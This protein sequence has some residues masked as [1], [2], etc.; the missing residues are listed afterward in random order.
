MPLIPPIL[1][2]RDFEAIYAEL[3]DRIPV[4]NPAWT[5][6]HE[7]DPGIT[8]L[9]LFA[10]LGEGLQFRFNQIPEATRLAFLKLL[11]L[12]LAPAR[13]AHAL[14]RCVSRAPAGVAVYAGDQ[15]KAGK[16]V[17]TVE[18]DAVLWPLDCVAVARAPLL[19]DPAGEL[20][21]FLA[22]LDAEL[23]A[24][25][26][27]GID[28]LQQADPAISAVAPY[29]PR[30]LEADATSPPLD[31]ADTVDGCVWIAVLK[32]PG[33]DLENVP[34]RAITLSLGYEPAVHYPDIDGAPTCGP[35]APP[36]LEWRASLA[37]PGRDG[38][39]A[40][41]ALRVAG[42]SSA[43]FT[44]AGVVSLEL[45][46]DLAPLGVPAAPAGVAGGGDHPPPLDDERAE[47]VW[48]WLRVWRGDGSRVGLTRAIMVNALAC[49]QAVEAAPELLGG[50]T[51]QPGQM[52]QLA[53]A[54][55]LADARHP[56][57]VQVEEGGVWCDWRWVDSFDASGREDRHFTLDAEAAQIRF[58]ER[59]PQLGERV[60][61]LGY[62]WGGGARGNLPAQALDAFVARGGAPTPPAPL[63]RAPAGIKLAN[64]LPARGG[65]DRESVEAALQRIP[66]TLRHNRRAVARDDFAELARQTPGADIGRAECLPLFHAPS[67]D[68]RAGNVGVVVWPARDPVHPDAPTPDALQL[69]NVC[70]WLDHARLVTTELHVI[71]PTYRRLALSIALKIKPGYGLNAVRD[72]VELLL[73]QYLAP[74]PPYGPD[75][76]GWP[77]GRAVRA[78]ELEGVAMQ[79]EGVEYV[80]ALRLA[81]D[82]AE[83]GEA[84]NWVERALVPLEDWEVPT[85]ADVVVVAGDAAPEP[86]RDLAPPP[87]TPPLPLPVLRDVCD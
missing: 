54:P 41:R 62:R 73:R 57:R 87:V 47:R 15:V 60:R 42:D 36:Q 25:V 68:Y 22:G 1:D 26:Q 44:R 63:L 17:F 35:G 86:G 59:F 34:G 78:R 75:G 61:V 58:G 9:Q 65:V 76:A 64:P 21:A 33:L 13:P 7:S 80:E 8:L 82:T 79:A 30:L 69:A 10:Y 45:P 71:P 51:G 72:W 23:R 27:A 46:V 12:P 37:Q 66:A 5:D 11:G 84:A 56:V 67:R 55:V 3:R 40:Y 32:A 53:Y 31:F 28:A 14:V 48:F 50:G 38:L 85:V 19:A 83:P 81:H 2:D 77:L 70:A 20:P 6:H 4:Y 29:E 16:V 18:H 74:L 24:A 52:F 39:P 43:G 49:Q